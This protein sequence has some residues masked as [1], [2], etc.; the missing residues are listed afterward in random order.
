M[1]EGAGHFPI[2]EKGLKQLEEYC[3]SFLNKHSI[4]ISGSA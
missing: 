1:L 4:D 2:E 3:I